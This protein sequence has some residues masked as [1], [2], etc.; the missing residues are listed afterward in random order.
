M[1]ILKSFILVLAVS[2]IG[3]GIY[4]Y[5]NPTGDNLQ[6]LLQISLFMLIFIVVLLMIIW[7]TNKK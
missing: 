4:S 6:F 1:N 2:C 3:I 7:K 5:F